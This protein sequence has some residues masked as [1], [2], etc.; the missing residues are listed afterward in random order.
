[1]K[2]LL[3]TLGCTFFLAGCATS[4]PI[5][6]P[7]GKPAYLVKC[8]GAVIDACYKKA[9][10]VC[11][12]GYTL[13]EKTGGQNGMGLGMGNSMTFTKTTNTLLVECQQ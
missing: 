7:N 2:L 8:G 5:Q 10:E 4:K 9:A 11:P 1:M 6:G 12:D 13:L 3:M